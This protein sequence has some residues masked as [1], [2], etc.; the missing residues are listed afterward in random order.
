[1][2]QVEPTGFA[3]G[4]LYEEVRKGR[5]L[6]FWC[7]EPE[8]LKWWWETSG[9]HMSTSPIL[10]THLSL[11]PT[12]YRF[13]CLSQLFTACSLTSFIFNFSTVQLFLWCS[14]CYL[15]NFPFIFNL[16]LIKKKA[17]NSNASR[18]KFNMVK[19][20]AFNTE[21]LLSSLLHIFYSETK[22][23]VDCVLENPHYFFEVLWSW[24]I[25]KIFLDFNFFHY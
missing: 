22:R 16:L 3:D 21:L 17:S 6:G 23:S 13:F 9:R 8:E 14:I 25:R 4:L 15:V 7:E 1:M 18:A 12:P 2:L 11:A 19:I 24:V 20:M 10:S 5:Y